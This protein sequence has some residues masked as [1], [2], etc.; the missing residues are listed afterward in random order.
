MKK[1]IFFLSMV[2]VFHCAATIAQ[3]SN[4]FEIAKNLEIYTTLYKEL[5]TN[6]VDDIK[7]GELMEAGIDAMLKT[8]DPY[9]V[10]I[11][12]AEVEDFRFMTTG[13]YGGIGALIHKQ[14]DYVVIAEPYEGN[15]AQKSGLLAGDRITKV[16]G[17]DVTGYSTT[18]VSAILKGQPGTSVIV[19]VERESESIEK[20]II[21]ENVKID[22]IPYYAMLDE[23]T[24]Y[25][26]LS[27][28][29]QDA[30]QDVKKAFT[31][32]KENNAMTGLILDLRG[33]GG[34]LLNEAVSITNLF[35]DKGRLVVS[36]KG[37]L[38]N[39]NKSY[40]TTLPALDQEIPLVILV[41]TSS[42]SASE[43]V[44]GAVQDLD[45]GIIIGQNTYGKGLV[46]NVIP[47]SYNTQM[48][49]TVAKY[50]IPSGRCIQAIDYTHKDENGKTEKT[51]DSLFTA[52]KTLNGRT[53]YD[54]GGIEPDIEIDAES[55]SEISYALLTEFVIFDYATRFAKEHPAIDPPGEFHI[56]DDIFADFLAYA[57]ER[58]YDYVPVSE[59]ALREMKAAAEEEGYYASLESEF[60]ALEQ[61]IAALKL[62]DIEKHN[63]EIRKLLKLEI[64]SRYYFQKGKIISSLSDDP[65][66]IK[67]REV[68]DDQMAYLAI[69]GGSTG[70]DD[71]EKT[72]KQP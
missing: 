4:N 41:D 32:L 63:I 31:G 55:L 57:S 60:K 48:K 33:N 27:G 39:K 71:P 53:V 34:G 11:P 62:K 7:P 1:S 45:R 10:F 3:N 15:P 14:G 19:T 49:V 66:I 61:S 21:R 37:K 13:Q 59:L 26:K 8:L 16:D 65:V 44:A 51:P 58:D 30:G 23:G 72:D 43:I 24:G 38:A 64:I 42:A 67:A 29:T 12:E 25:I 18:D 2:L 50:Y 28:F 46:Q 20:T 17:K 54:G 52:F 9:T 5:N 56:S 6:Y 47:L 68:L 40:K 22:N 35:V 69:I 36:T 70:P